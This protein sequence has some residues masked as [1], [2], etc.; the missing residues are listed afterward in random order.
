MYQCQVNFAIFYATS[1]LGISWQ[2][3]NHLNLLFSVYFYLG[4]I[5]NHLGI[6]LQYEDTFVKVKN[7]Y[8]RSAY[9]SICD[10]YGLNTNEMD[11]WK[12]VLY[13]RI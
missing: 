9:D 5:L 3:L 11:E 12:L 2:H 10:D 1:A 6:Y 13:C 8:F 7:H 4:V